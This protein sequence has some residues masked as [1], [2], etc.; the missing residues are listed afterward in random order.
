MQKFVFKL[1]SVLNLKKQIEDNAKNNLAKSSRILELEK[2][3]LVEL[4]QQKDTYLSK[5]SE[6]ME[7]GVPVYR[8]RGYNDYFS[9][10]KVR[11]ANQ[12]DIVNNAQR[13]VDINREELVK[14][15]QEKKILVKLREK[16]MEAYKIEALK[17][18]QKSIDELNS[19]KFREDPGEKDG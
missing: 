11:I 6:D 1:E 14:A 10:A 19:Y 5:M 17:D 7:V 18:E 13:I 4:N 16:K 15:V 9:G 12:K 3:V 2:G 8:L